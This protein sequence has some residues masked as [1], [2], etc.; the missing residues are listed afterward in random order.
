MSQHIDLF[1]PALLKKRDW[2]SLPNVV[3][4]NVL[5][6]LV[7]FGVNFYQQSVLAQVQHSHQ[8]R[9]KQ[10][11]TVEARLRALTQHSDLS[12]MRQAQ[13]STLQTLTQQKA[14]QSKVLRV[15]EQ[16]Q[17]NHQ[18]HHLLDYMQALASQQIKGVWL[19]GFSLD[20]NN[21]KVSVQGQA[22]N[23]DLIPE[24][25][26]S[27]GQSAVFKG[28]TFGGL[29]VQAQEIHKAQES[30]EKDKLSTLVSAANNSVGNSTAS[31]S[32]RPAQGA[33]ESLSLVSFE[34]GDLEQISS[35]SV[36]SVSKL[37]TSAAAP[38]TNELP[39]DLPTD[40]SALSQLISQDSAA[41]SSALGEIAIQLLQTINSGKT[42]HE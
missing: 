15:L 29:S 30:R 12:A 21:K 14:E 6:T 24:Y 2:V 28:Q 5:C 4:V 16:I 25:I 31:K 38:R 40:I 34:I 17:S 41:Q 32:E 23:A 33:N 10:L 8:Q 9:E 20:V 19:T 13:Q 22:L 7:M 39:S 37:A 11:A 26:A 35:R 1:N 3:L 18:H 42:R 36:E 27:L